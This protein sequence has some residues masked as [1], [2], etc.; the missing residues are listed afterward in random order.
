MSHTE[1]LNI[2]AEFNLSETCFLI[3]LV[4]A[5]KSLPIKTCKCKLWFSLEFRLLKAFEKM[6]ILGAASALGFAG[7]PQ[8]LKSG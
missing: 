2:S 8:L 6:V 1:Y 7:L 5:F 3:S 4:R